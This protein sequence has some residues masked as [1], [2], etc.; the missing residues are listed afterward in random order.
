[1]TVEDTV[2]EFVLAEY[3]P[4]TDPSELDREYDLL[5]SGVIDSLSLLKLMVWLEERF[6]IRIGDQDVSPDHF[7]SVEQIAR[8]V[9][10]VQNV[11]PESVQE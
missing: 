1:M 9:S 2:K 5:A 7:R 4:G 3:L 11:T 8:F 10:T 6:T